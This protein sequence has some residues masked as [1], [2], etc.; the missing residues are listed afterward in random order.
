MEEILASIRRI[1]SDE[2]AAEP[3]VS[4]SE[5]PRGAASPPV[6][7]IADVP[8][9]V[10][11]AQGDAAHGKGIENAEASVPPSGAPV[12]RASSAVRAAGEPRS[13]GVYSSYA[14]VGRSPAADPFVSQRRQALAA[15]LAP[16][17]VEPAPVAQMPAF[18]AASRPE[19]ALS[20]PFVSEPAAAAVVDD[21][22]LSASLSAALFDLSLV[23]QAVQAE[24]A[25]MTADAAPHA[26]IADDETSDVESSDVGHEPESV[27]SLAVF[28]ADTADSSVAPHPAISAPETDDMQVQAKAA[29]VPQRAAGS[30]PAE[31]RR[32][33][34][35]RV[36]E[37]ARPSEPRF[38]PA[39]ARAS[40]PADAVPSPEAPSRLVSTATNAAVS[41]AF[42]TLARTVASNS[43]T[44]DDLVTEAL[45]PM[46]KAWL[47]ENLPTL[48][49]RLVRAE[50]ERVA[51]QGQ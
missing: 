1:I 21:A 2:V 15:A 24:L 17:A 29:H 33:I 47:D 45:R 34:E 30:E 4:R 6:E 26:V 42:G 36:S 16:Q 14:P 12:R 49:E 7:A 20:E 28:D 10:S 5:N 3:L 48:V 32:A 35:T 19:R 41:T 50:I 25:T 8:A 43:R 39:S 27:V 11:D 22:D 9:V 51:R 13:P 18:V 31:E 40:S 44:V 23:E 46:L 37:A 38:L